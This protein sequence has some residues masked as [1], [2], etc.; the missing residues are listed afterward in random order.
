MNKS[1]RREAVTLENQGEK[2][3]G[4]LHRPLTEQKGP[5]ILI[6]SGFAGNKCGKYRLFVR[7]AQELSSIGIT[8]LRF[9]YRGAGDSEGDFTNI[10]LKGKVEDAIVCLQFLK[11]DPYVDS[12]KMGILGR[13]LGGVISLLAAKNFKQI[14]SIA[15]WAPV[16]SSDHWKDLWL[17]FQSNK[18]DTHQKKE[19]QNLPFGIPNKAFIQEFFALDMPHELESLK[20][21]PLLH[22]EAELDKVVNKDH[23]KAYRQFRK[24]AAETQFLNLPKSDHDFS[25][26]TDQEEAIKVTKEWF[27]KT[28]C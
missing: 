20:D 2:I 15:L 3:F 16:F 5:A 18:L 7:L 12:N 22:V 24:Q 10:T 1:E 8:V 19:I 23:G 25:D 17:S 9:D 4:V 21:I 11:N 13:S 26:S 6:C 27:K 28:L 14:K